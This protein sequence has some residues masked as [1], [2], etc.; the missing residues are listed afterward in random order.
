MRGPAFPM[1]VGLLVAWAPQ[2]CWA[3]GKLTRPIPRDGISVGRAGLDENNPVSFELG[4]SG[5]MNRCDAF[6]CREAAP[7]PSVNMA[8]VTAGSTLQL[9]WSFTA[10]H[11]GDCSVYI[12]YDVELA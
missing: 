2:L 7:N 9:Q 4:C 12:S 10:F 6:V 11:V 5:P 1:F 3:H 8:Q